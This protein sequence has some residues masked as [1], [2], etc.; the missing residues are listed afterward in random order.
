MQR[1]IA[2]PFWRTTGGFTLL[3]LMIVV[4]LVGILAQWGLPA[5][6]G[7]S[8]R[9]AL[10]AETS[11][12]QSALTLARHTAITR[13]TPV[14]VCPTNAERSHCTSQWSAALLVMTGDVSGDVSAEDIVRVFPAGSGTQTRYRTDRNRVRY[15]RLGHTSGFN[16]SF[17]VCPQPMS[18]DTMGQ[19][20]ILSRYGRLRSAPEAVDCSGRD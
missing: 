17:T 5:L 13:Q 18:A 10:R 6:S 11:R 2:P 14:T 3:E 20:L 15:S 1:P 12:L 16:G 8:E 19:A 4:L 9:N 7:V